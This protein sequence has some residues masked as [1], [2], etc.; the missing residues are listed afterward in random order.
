MKKSRFTW[1]APK[2]FSFGA[3]QL[4]QAAS[5]PMRDSLPLTD[6][7]GRDEKNIG[8]FVAWAKKATKLIYR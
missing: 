4:C 5:G 6:C 1:V 2:V 3:E 7:V 8:Y